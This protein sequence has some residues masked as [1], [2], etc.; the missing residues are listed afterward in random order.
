METIQI[1]QHYMRLGYKVTFQHGALN[2]IEVGLMKSH[3]LI[4]Q[5]FKD[6]HITPEYLSQIFSYMHDQFKPVRKIKG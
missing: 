1:I 3:K 6:D 2:H 5:Q 4:T